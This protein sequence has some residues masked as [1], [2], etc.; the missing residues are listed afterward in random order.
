[1]DIVNDGNQAASSIV[2]QDEEEEEDPLDAFMLDVSNQVQKLDQ[3]DLEKEEA[4]AAL[5]ASTE[6]LN[7]LADSGAGGGG[8]RGGGSDDEDGGKGGVDR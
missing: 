7:Q 3:E 8:G 4:A 2:V 5:N 1:M 6:S